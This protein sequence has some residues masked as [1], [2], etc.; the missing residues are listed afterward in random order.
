MKNE[1]KINLIYCIKNKIILNY[2]SIIIIKFN[3]FFKQKKILIIFFILHYIIFFIF[4]KIYYFHNFNN[5]ISQTQTKI[6]NFRETQE[7]GLKYIRNKYES[8]LDKLPFYNHTHQYSNK[9]FWCWLQG[10]QNAPKLYQSNLNALRKN[11]KNHEI[12][13]ITEKNMNQYIN[14]PSFIRNKF[15]RNLIP[16]THFSDMLRLELLKKYG[17]TW[18]DASVL[19]TEYDESFFNNDLF[20]FKSSG[21]NWLSG[22]SWFITGEKN[23]PILK[24]TL[25]LLYEFWRTNNKLYNYFLFH[26]F[27][28]MSCD[29]YI[30]D[31]KNVPFYSNIPVHVLQYEMFQSFNIRRY[32]QILECSKVH[33]LTSKTNIKFTNETFYYYILKEYS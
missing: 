31:F 1:S 21:E 11:C 33:K 27:F 30:N 6:L 32:K 9:I 20:F 25:D 23:S 14:F 17:G 4:I 22:S 10:E 15:N 19:I 29:R 12:I 16:K 13:I 28:K 26:F 5:Y 18:I 8:F 3:N 24:T 2:L 7:I